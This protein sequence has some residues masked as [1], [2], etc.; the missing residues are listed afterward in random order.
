MINHGILFMLFKNVG[1]LY[2]FWFVHFSDLEL[3]NFLTI[4]KQVS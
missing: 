3:F 1:L 2:G 4:Y